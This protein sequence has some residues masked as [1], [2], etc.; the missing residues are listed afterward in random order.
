[1]V[2]A[3][4]GGRVQTRA[5]LKDERWKENK[6][7]VVYDAQAAPSHAR[8]PAEDYEGAK[9]L[10][11]T[12]AATMKSW[13]DMGWLLRLEAE[14]R[15]Y[16]QAP[17]KLFLADGAPVLRSLKDLQFP[18]AVFILD[19]AHAAEHVSQDA[20]ALFGQGTAKAI[21]WYARQKERLWNGQMDRFI[22]ELQK[23][24]RA[25]GAPQV[26]D[27]DLSARVL[28]HR[29]AYSYFPNNKDAIRYP[30]FRSKGWPI[31]SGVAESAVKQF[32]LRLKGSEKFWN[33][34]NTGAEEMLALCAL[35]HS[36]DGRWSRYWH[37]REQ[38]ASKVPTTSLPRHTAD[39]RLLCGASP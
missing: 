28:L 27:S 14:K 34:D 13:D 3:A 24:A 2:I 18:E 39:G 4:D 21:Q 11:K 10:V 25:L 29:D 32:A 12:Y 8:T 35:Y 37:Q 19:W 38:P 22:G 7:G 26:G 30:F 15:G 16:R 31:G 9:A 6:I 36:E 1:L 33:I 5:P 20:R 23:Q 17:E